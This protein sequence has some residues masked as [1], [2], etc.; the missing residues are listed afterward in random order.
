M[1]TPRFELFLNE[2]LHNDPEGRGRFDVDAD[3]LR[4]L[5]P[6][7]IP[8][9]LYPLIDPDNRIKTMR[10][11]WGQ[12]ITTADKAFKSIYNEDEATQ[13]DRQR[14]I[15]H[16]LSDIFYIEYRVIYEGYKRYYSRYYTFD[17]EYFNNLI[18]E[19]QRSFPRRYAEDV[20]T[21]DGVVMKSINYFDDLITDNI[22]G[23]YGRSEPVSNR[24]PEPVN[25]YPQIFVNGYAWKLFKYWFDNTVDDEVKADNC[26][27]YWQMKQDGLI[28][29]IRPQQYK[30]WIIEKPFCFDFGDYWKQLHRV[31]TDKRK[32]AYKTTMELIKAEYKVTNLK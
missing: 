5:F 9:R 30:Q 26:Y 27:M 8:P 31:N 25:E 22:I 21:I 7:H 17:R 29:D 15:H 24:P 23:K 3:T 6:D 2:W 10:I 11:D 28:H 18:L 1:E 12:W 4:E 14:F 32:Q 19:F 20:Q 13:E 16:W